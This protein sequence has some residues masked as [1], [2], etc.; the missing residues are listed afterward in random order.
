MTIFDI[1]IR[2][3]IFYPLN[4]LCDFELIDEDSELIE[5]KRLEERLGSQY[6]DIKQ[7][8]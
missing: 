2:N 4:I 8:C 6:I 1:I 5:E 3:L 7:Y